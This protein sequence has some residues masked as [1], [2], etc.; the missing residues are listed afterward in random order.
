MVAVFTG[1][2]D[3]NL[4]NKIIQG[5]GK[6]VSSCTNACNLVIAKNPA[7]NSG[8]LQKARERGV[9]I[10]SYNEALERFI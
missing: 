6:V 1:I 8:K 9:E 3:A 7:E 4:Q 2:R 10:I 5:G